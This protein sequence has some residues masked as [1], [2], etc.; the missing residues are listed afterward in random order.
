MW[1][2][3]SAKTKWHNGKWLGGLLNKNTSSS[4]SIATG[5]NLSR[6]KTFS[7]KDH[8]HQHRCSS[9]PSFFAPTGSLSPIYTCRH[10]ALS[11]RDGCPLHKC[12]H[13]KSGDSR[14]PGAIGWLWLERGPL[15]CKHNRL[16]FLLGQRKG[17]EAESTSNALCY[18]WDKTRIM[19]ED[20][21]GAGLGGTGVVRGRALSLSAAP[22]LPVWG[23]SPTL[24]AHWSHPRLRG[25]SVLWGAVLWT[26]NY[27]R[28]I[29]K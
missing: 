17:S 24:D 15:L 2:E 26:A 12:E 18:F 22:P 7:G 6:R 10:I 21:G 9:V 4:S 20:K 23:G 11:I 29:E 13:M 27:R 19:E 1:K 14:F 3:I 16:H 25:A 8:Q 28:K 5:V